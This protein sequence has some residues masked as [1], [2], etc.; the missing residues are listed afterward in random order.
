MTTDE[1]ASAV[2]KQAPV[3]WSHIRMERPNLTLYTS[4]M[5]THPNLC[6]GPIKGKHSQATVIQDLRKQV[7]QVGKFLISVISVRLQ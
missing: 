1:P 5:N 6:S 4:N 7:N 3:H 2:L